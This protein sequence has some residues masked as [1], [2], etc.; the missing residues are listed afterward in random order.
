MIKDKNGVE[1]KEGDE[2]IYKGDYYE[3][4]KN[5]FNGRLAI[6]ND[7]GQCFLENIAIKEC[8]VIT[9]EHKIKF[10]EEG[11]NEFGVY[12]GINFAELSDEEL[13]KCVDFIDYLWEK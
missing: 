8:E 7:Y 9:R 3:V 10:C 13:K 5:D 4:I 12:G 6:D 2:V 11:R 1:I